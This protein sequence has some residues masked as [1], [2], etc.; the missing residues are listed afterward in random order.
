MELSMKT[1]IIISLVALVIVY[2]AFSRSARAGISSIFV[3]Q[4]KDDSGKDTSVTGSVI[5]SNNACDKMLKSGCS[6]WKVKALQ[7]ALNEV[8]GDINEK[9]GGGAYGNVTG[10]SDLTVDGVYGSKTQAMLSAI[11]DQTMMYVPEE[12]WTAGADRQP[13]LE[14]IYWVG[15]RTK[16]EENKGVTI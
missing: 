9:F 8:K 5:V 12:M 3:K 11:S 14:G 6:G 15:L 4:S 13:V 10:L 2:L 7:K 16:F 1:K